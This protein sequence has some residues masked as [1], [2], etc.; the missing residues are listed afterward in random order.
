VHLDRRARRSITL[1]QRRHARFVLRA[2]FT[3]R[4]VIQDHD[5]HRRTSWFSL[6][7]KFKI[8]DFRSAMEIFP[9][10]IS[11]DSRLGSDMDTCQ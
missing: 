7:E 9:T 10:T 2:S 11:K 1:E 4:L 6:G 8:A 5:A 3:F